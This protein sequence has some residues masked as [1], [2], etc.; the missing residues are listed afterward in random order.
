MKTLVKVI[1]I[2]IVIITGCRQ[3]PGFKGEHFF[4][5]NRWQRFDYVQFK[6]PVE[7]GD[8]FDLH[9]TFIHS[10]LFNCRSLP[11]NITIYKPGGEYRSRDILVHLKD[12]KMKWRSQ[13]ADSGY[14]KRTIRIGKA[15]TFT[16]KGFC[17]VRIE[18]KYPMYELSGVHKLELWAERAH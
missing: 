13:P 5:G 3:K 10:N 8:V 2:S 18:Q 1:F 16:G 4:Q 14:L 17:K 6:I 9:L 7:K 11:L 12:K 15:L